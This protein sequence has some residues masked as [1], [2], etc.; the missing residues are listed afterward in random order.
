MWK[1]YRSWKFLGYHIPD[2]WI[3]FILLMILKSWVIFLTVFQG[4]SEMLHLQNVLAF[5]RKLFHLCIVSVVSFVSSD[6]YAE[7]Y[8]W[9][10][11]KIEVTFTLHSIFLPQS[12]ILFLCILPS[13]LT[14]S[15]PSFL[16]SF[17]F[18]SF[19]PFL[20]SFVS[21]FLKGKMLLK[22]VFVL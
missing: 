12:N 9:T 2:L 3:S 15:L 4:L 20:S 21:F 1:I 18:S 16:P 17:I 10:T 7:S 11:K 19:S 5:S 6:Y 8:S 13:S 22:K 14:P